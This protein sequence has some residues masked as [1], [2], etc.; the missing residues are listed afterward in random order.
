MVIFCL[1]DVPKRVTSSCLHACD[2]PTQLL[3]SAILSTGWE[4]SYSS[5]VPLKSVT[6]L[7]VRKNVRKT[8]KK[9]KFLD[10]FI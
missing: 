4:T 7:L 10:T 8:R 1:R 3:F 5:R 2:T 9:S 6:Y